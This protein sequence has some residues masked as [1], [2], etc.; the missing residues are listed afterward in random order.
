MHRVVCY[1]SGRYKN[2][3]SLYVICIKISM[4][5]GCF[6]VHTHYILYHNYV[7]RNSVFGILSQI[8]SHSYLATKI[9]ND[10]LKDGQKK[11]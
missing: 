4:Y 9:N 6:S 5:D 10:R 1:A 11:I 7:H 8:Q 3:I 2:F